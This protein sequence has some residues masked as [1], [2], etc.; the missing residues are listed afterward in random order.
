MAPASP[1]HPSTP[2]S[3]VFAYVLL[4]I[5]LETCPTGTQLVVKDK[6]TAQCQQNST[7]NAC[8]L[9]CLLCSNTTVCVVC[10][11]YHYLVLQATSNVCVRDSL[12]FRC[13]APGYALTSGGVC[14][15]N[16]A[17]T[18][19]ALSR[20]TAKVANCQLC[21]SLST[22]LCLSCS[23]G[24]FLQDNSCVK[25]CSQSY[26][27][28][29]QACLPSPSNCIKMGFFGGTL[30]TSFNVNAVTINQGYLKLTQ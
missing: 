6:L 1:V 23:E 9:S 24:Y 10:K 2:S 20:C 18:L 7:Q 8:P 11:P 28:A 29:N 3:T 5:Y 4:A 17:N 26:Y 27:K 25:V 14:Y 15:P 30:N 19:S 13:S 12:L 22:S 16:D 21:L